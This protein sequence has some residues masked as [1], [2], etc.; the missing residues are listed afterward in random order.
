MTGRGR[1][2]DSELIG[3]TLCDMSKLLE[4]AEGAGGRIRAAL[5][6][7]GKLVPYQQCALLDAEAGFDPRLVAV[8]VMAPDEKAELA[9]ELIAL[10]G[11]ML[12]ER[13]LVPSSPLVR[14][15]SHLAVPLIGLDEVIGV[16]FVHRDEGTYQDVE[17]RL[18]SL[19]AAQL[20]A[21]L[22]MLRARGEAA[23]SMRD[24]KCAQQAAESALLGT[25]ELVH[26]FGEEISTPLAAA[27]A[28]AR[29]L[30]SGDLAPDERARVAEAIEH[31]VRRQAR[32]I[33]ELLDR[34]SFPVHKVRRALRT[35]AGIGSLAAALEE[36]TSA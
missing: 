18:L 2:A 12:E 19:A 13:A 3:R 1:Q 26:L 17:L 31:S 20:A 30:A 21:Y 25:E 6:L 8:P 34:S 15:H 4:S 32:L 22:T 33:G 36:P 29:A 14:W 27:V 28:G 23:A 5:E 9:S 10:L 7:L 35:L 16:L 11:K 24:L